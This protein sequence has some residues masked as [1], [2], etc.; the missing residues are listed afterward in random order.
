MELQKIQYEFKCGLKATQTEATYKS[1]KKL[2]RI[3]IDKL[4]VSSIQD[5]KN[6]KVSVL[7]TQF[8][9]SD[10]LLEVLKVILQP[11]TDS[12]SFDLSDLT[13]E[14]I[15]QVFNDFFILSPSLSKKLG[16]GKSE[17]DSQPV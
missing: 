1:D 14:E 6:T 15:I 11:Q 9:E 17:P 2:V 13:R 10:I 4:D 8:I 7:I 3:L 16:I 12:G 5:I